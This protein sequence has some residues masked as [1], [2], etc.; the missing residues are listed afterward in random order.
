MSGG[1]VGFCLSDKKRK[2][3]NLDAFA[4]FCEGRGVEVVQSISVSCITRNVKSR[5]Q[6]AVLWSDNMADV[7]SSLRRRSLADLWLG[8]VRPGRSFWLRGGR[9]AALPSSETSFHE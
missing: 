9:G 5:Q 3:M 4:V 7:F 8:A 1:R 2:R 6:K